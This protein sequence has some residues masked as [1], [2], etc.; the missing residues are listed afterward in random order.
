MRNSGVDGR[1]ARGA[2][3]GQHRDR[4]RLLALSLGNAIGISSIPPKNLVRLC[5][6]EGGELTEL[7]L[8]AASFPSS[9]L[10]SANDT[11]TKALTHHVGYSADKGSIGLEKQK[12]RPG[13]RLFC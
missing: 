11:T 7:K 3:L 9:P 6:G 4:S 8:A 5:L 1:G 2:F 12:S 13:G 10:A